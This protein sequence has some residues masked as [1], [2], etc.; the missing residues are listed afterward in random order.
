[1]KKSV[2]ADD[3]SKNLY[4][5]VNETLTFTSHQHYNACNFLAQQRIH[6]GK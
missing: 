6:Y 2:Y 3:L 4:R 1:M 5:H